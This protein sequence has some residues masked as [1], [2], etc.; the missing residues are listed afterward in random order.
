MLQQLTEG[1]NSRWFSGRDVLNTGWR[2]ETRASD[3]TGQ[4]GYFFPN[5]IRIVT[6]R[7]Q[8]IIVVRTIM[9]G[10]IDKCFAIVDEL[11][12]RP[13]AARGNGAKRLPCRLLLGLAFPSGLT[14]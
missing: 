12:T 8:K 5:H 10:F 13:N 3:I 11:Q 4:V 14:R 6:Y 2:N 7:S 9:L 1:Y